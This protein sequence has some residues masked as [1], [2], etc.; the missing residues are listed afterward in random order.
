MQL[1][2]AY[3]KTLGERE[4][5]RIAEENGLDLVVVN[6]SFVVGPLL[7]PQPASTLLMILSIVKGYIILSQMCCDVKS[8]LYSIAYF[9]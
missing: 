1:W 2:Y 7:A 5:W 8:S 6:P 3:A 9:L 4:A